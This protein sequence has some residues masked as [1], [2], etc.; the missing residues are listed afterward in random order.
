MS[1]EA[2]IAEADA[3]MDRMVTQRSSDALAYLVRFNYRRQYKLPGLE[4]DLEQALSLGS[5]DLKVRLIAA[6]HAYFQARE[7]LNKNGLKSLPAASDTPAGLSADQQAAMEGARQLFQQAAG[8][9]QHVLDKIEPQNTTAVL[10]VGRA[11]VSLSEPDKAATLWSETLTKPGPDQLPIRYF[12]A[13]LYVNQQN[14]IA[15]KAVLEDL[16]K[17]LE[18]FNLRA[19]RAQFDPLRNSVELMRARM[20]IGQEQFAAA[21]PLLERVSAGQPNSAWQSAE[22]CQAYRLAGACHERAGRSDLAARS[23]ENAAQLAVDVDE[24]A[25]AYAGA[26][27]AWESAGAT[28]NALADAERSVKLAPQSGI[29]PVVRTLA[30]RRSN[31]RCPSP[32][33]LRIGS[34]RRCDRG[35]QGGQ[36]RTGKLT[37]GWR[38]D[39][40]IADARLVRATTAEDASAALDNVYQ[41][42]RRAEEQYPKDE[43]LL[44]Q[45]IV[46][47]HRLQKA[48]DADRVLKQFQTVTSDAF[49]RQMAEANLRFARQQYPEALACLEAVGTTASPADQITLVKTKAQ[50][51]AADGKPKDAAEILKKLAKDH[52]DDLSIA[53]LRLQ[54]VDQLQDTAARQEL[55]T[56]LLGGSQDDKSWAQAMKIQRLVGEAKTDRDAG[57]LEALD[58]I[59]RLET[60]RPGWSVVYSLRGAAE[61]QRAALARAAGATEDQE[62]A[63]LEQAARAYER[64]M[65][66]GDRTV[67]IYERL[68]NTLYRAGRF[69][70]ATAYL[71]RIDRTV[72]LSSALSEVAINIALQG[73]QQDQAVELARRAME[74]RRMT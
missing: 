39:L 73:K 4:Q 62:R 70:D 66:L 30:P 37:A 33:R 46:A 18:K 60:A 24:Q 20:L 19:D 5:D 8:H 63:M 48:D 1:R 56:E 2:R 52:P 72:P 41:T 29:A 54:V 42:A 12:L 58:L 15:A 9:F 21:L 43:L 49:A 71:A 26:A 67:G 17:D 47:Y 68:V 44:R 38:L 61:E 40:L 11:F 7:M 53:R 10:G 28:E 25:A 65:A 13:Q 36:Q 50:I 23:L 22:H 74:T 3:L 59:A 27:A 34:V 57:F 31:R 55:E 64:A 51:L 14:W 69:Q 32:S 16:N 35:T 45:L 6:N